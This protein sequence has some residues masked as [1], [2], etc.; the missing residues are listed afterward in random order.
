MQFEP[1]WRPDT[2]IYKQDGS[3]SMMSLDLLQNSVKDGKVR[4]RGMR[5]EGK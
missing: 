4:K 2:G 1:T 5:S 3:A